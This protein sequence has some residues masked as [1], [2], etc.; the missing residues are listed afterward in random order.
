MKDNL[1]NSQEWRAKLLQRVLW[2][3]AFAALPS[4]VIASLTTSWPV[5]LV[6]LLIYL[7]ILAITIFPVPYVYR[8]WI[9]ISLSYLTALGNLL[10]RYYDG[11]VLSLLAANVLSMLWLETRP[12]LILTGIG[13]ALPLPFFLLELQAEEFATKSI[14]HY[15]LLWYSLII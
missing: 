8:A 3:V 10:E 4:L 9:A 12:A 1:S 7:T 15:G 14:L 11:G 2:I 6:Y 13:L 5:F